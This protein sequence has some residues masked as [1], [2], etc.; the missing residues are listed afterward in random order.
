MSHGSHLTPI[1]L[2]QVI[3]DQCKQLLVDSYVRGLFNCAIDDQVLNSDLI[4]NRKDR[5]DVANEKELQDAGS[6]SATA[7]AAQDAMVDR[8]K[9]FWQ[10]RWAK[11]LSKKM[12]R[13]ICTLLMLDW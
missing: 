2:S 10:S 6:S 4:I 3:R 9:K 12:V 13:S 8:S 7:L 5:K 11:K 1:V